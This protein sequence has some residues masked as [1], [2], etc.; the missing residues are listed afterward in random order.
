G[1]HV[2]IRAREDSGA[3]AVVQLQDA[4]D[5]FA[6]A[7]ASPE[8][9][10]DDAADL[11]A[12]ERFGVPDLDG[13]VGRDDRRSLV[14]HLAEDAAGD[15]DGG[16]ARTRL[17]AN[18]GRDGHVAGGLAAPAVVVFFSQYDRDVR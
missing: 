7:A 13:R 17:T 9:H 3:L 16:D 15:G 1:A 14:N 6:L 2:E 5:L 8:G 18:P 12:H 11:R 4:E 10:A